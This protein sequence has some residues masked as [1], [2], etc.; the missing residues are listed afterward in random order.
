MFRLCDF[1]SCAFLY[2]GIFEFLCILGVI[3]DSRVR[4]RLLKP[5]VLYNYLYSQS[6]EKPVCGNNPSIM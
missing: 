3:I 6:G 5:M 4:S 1:Y 2:K